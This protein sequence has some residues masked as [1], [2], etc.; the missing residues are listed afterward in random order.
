MDD[1]VVTALSALVHDRV[2]RRWLRRGESR[3]LGFVEA[4]AGSP[5]VVF[6]A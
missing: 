4:G 3:R 1:P 6:V 2:D 5:V